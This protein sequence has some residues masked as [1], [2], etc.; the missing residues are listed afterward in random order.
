MHYVKTS[1]RL[2]PLLLS[3]SR[4][5]SPQPAQVESQVISSP[6]AL[7][8]AAMFLETRYHEPVT[9]E[10]PVWLWRSDSVP[11]GRDPE[12]AFGFSLKDR[13]FD[14]PSN[15]T[16]DQTPVLDLAALQ[17]MLDAYHSQN[18]DGTLFQASE[19]RLGLHITPLQMH[20]EDGRLI[21]AMSLLD[22]RISVPVEARMPSEHLQALCSAIAAAAGYDLKPFFPQGADA[23]FRP[24]GLVPPKGAAQLLSAKEKQPYFISW[25]ASDM[26]AREALLSLIDRS[27]EKLSW[28]MLCH[29]SAKPENRFCVLNMHTISSATPLPVRR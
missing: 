6:H 1:A 3:L 20:A 11:G 14:M 19:S 21:P 13:V 10:E 17:R 16:P 29:P 22:T 27:P 9:F 25:G 15:L 7:F 2:L 8:N 5:A 18:N 12:G 26:P 23:V 28:D 4:A 24:N